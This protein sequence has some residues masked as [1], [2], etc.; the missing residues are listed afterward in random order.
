MSYVHWDDWVR[1]ED[2]A[3]ASSIASN[4]ADMPA[5]VLVNTEALNDFEANAVALLQQ[6]MPAA[7]VVPQSA[8]K[9]AIRPGAIVV[10][11]FPG[12]KLE[13]LIVAHLSGKD[14]SLVV[15][16]HADGSNLLSWLQLQGRQDERSLDSKDTPSG[17]ILTEGNR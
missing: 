13:R 15:L 16:L 2:G 7:L 10:A 1:Q 11:V 9:H 12:R 5:V 14:I 4:A 8:W 17:Q 6:S 3:V